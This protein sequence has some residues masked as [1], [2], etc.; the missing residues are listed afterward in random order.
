MKSSMMTEECEFKRG[1]MCVTHG[2]E[3]VKN[4]TKWQEW[5]LKKNGMY[6]YLPRQKTTY[7]CGGKPVLAGYLSPTKV[8]RNDDGVQ[9]TTGGRSTESGKSLPED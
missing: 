2:M 7:R 3:G 5:G 8:I 9:R 4:V 1:G 6:G